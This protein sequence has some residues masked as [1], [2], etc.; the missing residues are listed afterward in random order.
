MSFK[1]DIPDY[2][3]LQ[4]DTYNLTTVDDNIWSKLE[5]YSQKVCKTTGELIALTNKLSE[6]ALVPAT[7]NWNWDFVV[8]DLSY[9]INSI[10]Q[11]VIDGKFHLLMDAIEAIVA[12]G[13]LDLDEVDEFLLDFNLG[14]C[15]KYDNFS[16]K[17][18]WV[19]RDDVSDLTK[20][21]ESIQ[22]LIKDGFQQAIEHFEQAKKQ[23]A[24]A[25]SERAR[26]DA[27][28]DCASAMESIIKILG[29][30]DDIRNA[31]KK[32]RE[33]HVWG[34]DTIVKDGDSIFNT[35]HRLYPDLRHGSAEISRMSIEDA[36]Y[37]IDRI[38]AY[39]SYMIRMKE[40]LS[41]KEKRIACETEI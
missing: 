38:A 5:A 6:I 25:Q 10:G 36:Q 41:R 29:K 1:K 22:E 23:L 26:K 31:S 28:R 19:L 12:T 16:R 20:N 21:I 39:V 11:Q 13:S 33:Q 40:N 4:S 14:Y 3:T 7:K 8:Y 17:Y 2:K 27:V 30:D 24:N 9:A 32:L 15:L 18:H 37:W 34:E 35:L